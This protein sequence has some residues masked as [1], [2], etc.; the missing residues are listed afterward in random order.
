MDINYIQFLLVG[1]IYTVGIY[2]S[3]MMAGLHPIKNPNLREDDFIE[4]EKNN[5]NLKYYFTGLILCTIVYLVL[6]YLAYINISRIYLFL[7]VFIFHP[8]LTQ[9]IRLRFSD[10]DISE[11]ITVFTII[12]FPIALLLKILGIL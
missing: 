1:A 8:I 4:W 3:G 9:L 7:S 6:I 10:K 11:F 12:F 2:S 5:F